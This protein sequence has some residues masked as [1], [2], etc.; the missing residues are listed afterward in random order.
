MKTYSK[1]IS[2]AAALGLTATLAVAGTTA[3]VEGHE[4][5][6]EGHGHHGHHGMSMRMARKLNLTDAQKEQWK[7]AR[8]ATHEQNAA[9]FEQAKAT[10]K[11]LRAAREANDTAK[12]DA[13]KP[14]VEA[15][16]AQMKQLRAAQEQQF[17]SLLT[18]EQRTQF[19]ALKAAHAARRAQR[20]QSK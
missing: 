9:F 10:H 8:K 7:A 3:A 20:E 13:L 19:E 1:W 2:V 5:G 6:G 12:L 15:Q 11:E 16:R 17:V 14:T 18:P 4:H